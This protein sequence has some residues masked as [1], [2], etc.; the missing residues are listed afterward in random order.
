MLIRPKQ[1]DIFTWSCYCCR[2]SLSI[3]LL[4][5]VFPISN[6]ILG[7]IEV[8][9]STGDLW[10]AIHPVPS[11]LIHHLKDPAKLAPSQVSTFSSNVDDFPFFWQ[12]TWLNPPHHVNGSLTTPLHPHHP[13]VYHLPKAMCESKDTQTGIWQKSLIHIW[14]IG[15]LCVF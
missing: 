12:R 8:D 9:Q 11:L 4:L 3:L 7:N 14:D 13:V 2:C 15:F 6:E 5:Q 10:L 1:Q